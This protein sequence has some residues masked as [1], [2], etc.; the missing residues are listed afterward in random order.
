MMDDLITWLRAQIDD[1]EHK[2]AG[3]ERE[4]ERTR[5]APIFRNYPP[6]WLAGVDIFVS[7]KRWRDE[8][9]TKRRVLD[10]HG[11]DHECIA[12]TGS[13]DHSVVDGGPWELWE[14]ESTADHGPCFVIRC[15]ALPYA[16]RPGYREEW[17]P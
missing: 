2:I 5:T 13:G 7:P 6:D 10:A 12:L 16:N 17:R 11:L 9:D 8:V 15:L 1:D 14:P 3:M 4:Q